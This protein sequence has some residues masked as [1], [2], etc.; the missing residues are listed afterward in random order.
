MNKIKIYTCVTKDCDYI[1]LNQIIT[2][3]EEKGWVERVHIP[4][5]KDKRY[6]TWV[7]RIGG[8]ALEPSNVQSISD[9][10]E[11]VLACQ[12]RAEWKMLNEDPKNPKILPWNFYVRDWKSF[13]EVQSSIGFGKKRNIKSI[14]SGTIRGDVHARNQW[15]NST[16][17][18]SYRAAR[19]YNRTNFLYP[20]LKDYYTALS[21]SKF[22]LCPVG[23][24][25]ICQR[26]TETM[27]MGCVA[28]FTPGVEW[29]YYVSPVENVDFIT[30]K[31]VED[32]NRKIDS[33]S[34]N[35][36]NEISNNAVTYFNKYCSPKGLWDSVLGTIEKLSIRID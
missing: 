22:A 28:M 19:S 8:L 6:I 10:Y 31:N 20:T 13:S 9:T 1:G 14:F 26:E 3:W 2:Y 23:D 29:E 16:E 12:Y 34:E 32:M 33:M 30:V 35:D 4:M 15:K 21:Q 27:G 36:I 17:V 25:P 24:C 5:K 18:F 7:G 11:Y